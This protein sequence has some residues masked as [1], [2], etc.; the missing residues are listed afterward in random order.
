M[1][2]KSVRTRPS[3]MG[4]PIRQALGREGQPGRLRTDPP[5]ADGAHCVAF[6]VGVNDGGAFRIPDDLRGL[7]TDGRS[8]AGHDAVWRLRAPAPSDC[9][10]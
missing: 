3:S 6:A 8:Q 9:P 1:P 7:A 4:V 2:T 5:L 10:T